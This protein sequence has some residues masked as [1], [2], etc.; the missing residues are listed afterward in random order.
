VALE[1]VR[2][3]A[4]LLLGIALSVALPAS[5]AVDLNGHF[6]G[7]GFHP[8]VGTYPCAFDVTQVGTALTLSTQ[9]PP[10]APPAMASGTIDP[11]TGAFALATPGAEECGAPDGSDI[12]GTGAQDGYTFNATFV[13]LG[14]P[15]AIFFATRCAN[16]VLDPGE[17]QVCED[18]ASSQD[19]P[20]CTNRCQLRP[21]GTACGPLVAGPCD[22]QDRCDGSSVA[23]PEI[24]KPDGAPCSDSNF[25][26]TGDA[27]VGGT[28][29][30]SGYAPAGTDCL[31][32]T[33]ACIDG[34]C[35]GA[36]V[37]Q[38]F[39]TTAACDDH[40]ACTSG[41]ACDG[42]GICVGG[43]PV[44]CGACKEC[45]TID[46]CVPH[47]S[48]GCNR[49]SSAKS[50]L[51]LR[52]R[53]PDGG[54]SIGWKWR[55]GPPIASN[56]F[57]D[58]VQ[59]TDYTLCVYDTEGTA[60]PHLLLDANAPS[61]T[62]WRGSGGRFRY[63]SP[64]STPDGLKSLLLKAGATGTGRIALKGKGPNL[65]LPPTLTAVGTPVT[66]QLKAENGSCWEAVY[67]VARV[68]TPSAFKARAGSPGGAFLDD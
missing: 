2:L 65:G 5:A 50:V 7:E 68:S 12:H 41:D 36:G 18:V 9:C 34:Q 57:G 49:S 44:T 55:D 16:G 4:A 3:S 60:S 45:N 58:P 46:G 1:R 52:D 31:F 10:S 33:Y 17:D 51:S 32:T 47:V 6:T 64:T 11:T 39:A 59:G 27:C 48:S 8:L 20:C 35:D 42:M 53:S 22:E 67:P 63:G 66:V 56:E 24:E 23:C 54:D 30:A 25:C 43:P 14:V 37:C 38:L 28:C 61:G 19:R 13:C 15:R 29:V 21:S 62:A 40:N 26:T